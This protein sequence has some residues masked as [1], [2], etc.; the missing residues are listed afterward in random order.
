[1]GVLELFV[2]GIFFSLILKRPLVAAILGVAVASIGVQ[3]AITVPILDASLS[4][5]L[6]A[7]PGRLAIVALVAAA[8]TVLGSRWFHGENALTKLRNRKTKT[9]PAAIAAP[10][11]TAPIKT[12]RFLNV[13]TRLSWQQTRQS[14]WMWIW[15]FAALIVW[16]SSYYL[17]SGRY[18]R[19]GTSQ[20][21]HFV[22]PLV[23]GIVGL[24]TV[25]GLPLLGIYVFYPDQQRRKYHFFTERGA[26]PGQFW[27]SR[28]LAGFAIPF[29]MALIC[30]FALI[31][32]GNLRGEYPFFPYWESFRHQRASGPWADIS[33]WTWLAQFG[34]FFDHVLII[35]CV[36]QFWAMFIRSG[37]LAMAHEMAKVED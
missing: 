22:L 12:H 6:F 24:G 32:P 13:F 19:P 18:L 35:Y 20:P 11:D 3:V 4:P 16:L 33:P 34:I 31:I 2:W 21:G 23:M 30:Y 8:D 7:V 9:L 14:A 17:S 28:Q 37:I 25:I 26:R 27:W 15:F 1:V 29:L 10:H 5:Y 36:G